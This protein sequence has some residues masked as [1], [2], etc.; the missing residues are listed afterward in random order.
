MADAWKAYITEITKGGHV[1]HAAICGATDALVWSATDGFGVSFESS[2]FFQP[3]LHVSFAPAE[4]DFR[5]KTNTPSKERL[6]LD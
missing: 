2:G 1:T 5:G 4:L 6:L 3:A